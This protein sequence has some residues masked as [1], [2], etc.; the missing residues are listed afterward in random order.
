MRRLLALTA[1]VV[2][3]AAPMWGQVGSRD[4]VA[5]ENDYI[6]ISDSDS[7]TTTAGQTI[8]AWVNMDDATRFRIFS[9]YDSSTPANGWEYWLTVAG[10]DKLS[11]SIYDE[12]GDCSTAQ[13]SIGRQYST[14]L[15]AQEGVWLFI[16][17]TWDGGTTTAS[18]DLYVDGS[19]V[20]DADFNVSG[21]FTGVENCATDASMF[22]FLAPSSSNEGDGRMAYVHLYDRDLGVAEINQIMHCPGSIADGLVGYWPLTDSSTQYDLSPN[23]NN[24]TNSGTAASTDGPPITAN[25]AA[26]GGN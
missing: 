7:L 23:S 1:Y 22:A 24:G 10:D 11:Y 4:S 6:S 25:C 15:T 12:N 9:K 19:V 3:L 26:A 18:I 8:A 20:D 14:A 21:T 13:D 2:L 16:A 17:S 5:S